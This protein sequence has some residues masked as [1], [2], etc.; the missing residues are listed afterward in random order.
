MLNC[1]RQSYKQLNLGN[2]IA[3]RNPS[4]PS[5]LAWRSR[6]ITPLPGAKLLNLSSNP[7]LS[8]YTSLEQPFF[9]LQ[10]I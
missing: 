9:H 2:A 10:S 3:N 7:N 1:F 6:H 4:M 5:V 8:Y